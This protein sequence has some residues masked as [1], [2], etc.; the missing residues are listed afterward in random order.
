M[1]D[2]EMLLNHVMKPKDVVL[3]IVRVGMEHLYE[4]NKE[5][6]E[7][8]QIHF[9]AQF[10]HCVVNYPTL[11]GEAKEKDEKRVTSR[12]CNVCDRLYHDEF[13]LLASF[14]SIH[15]HKEHVPLQLQGKWKEC[16]ICFRSMCP[17][18]IA[19]NPTDP[20]CIICIRAKALHRLTA[21]LYYRYQ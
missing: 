16:T 7:F 14:Y 9:S 21:N 2:R 5:Q 10:G 13:Y 19:E 12:M 11:S 3:L 18:C 20:S 6:E 4:R 17:S 15:S 1:A 8:V